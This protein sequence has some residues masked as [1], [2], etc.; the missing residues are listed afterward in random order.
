MSGAH[1]KASHRP[2]LGFNPAGVLG[3]RGPLGLTLPRAQGSWAARTSALR[4]GFGG[5]CLLS[6][7]CLTA[8]PRPLLCICYLCPMGLED[9]PL[10]ALAQNL[11]DG[12]RVA[13]PTCPQR[14]LPLTGP[15]LYYQ[16]GSLSFRTQLSPTPSQAFLLPAAP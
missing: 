15:P 14:P 1:F 13:A 3:F 12:S 4:S 9:K 11:S 6:A 7:W 5:L 8:I 16:G 2:S 10:G